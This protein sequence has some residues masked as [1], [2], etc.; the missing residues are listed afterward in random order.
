M[1]NKIKT[2]EKEGKI[3]DSVSSPRK[4]VKRRNSSQK[5]LVQLTPERI[6]RPGKK[7]VAFSTQKPIDILTLPIKSIPKPTAKPKKGILKK[8][9]SL[10]INP[11]KRPT[12]YESE[13]SACWKLG[14]TQFSM[15]VKNGITVV[16]NPLYNSKEVQLRETLEEI[17][18][19]HVETGNKAILDL[20]AKELKHI[21]PIVLKQQYLNVLNLYMNQFRHLPSDIGKFFQFLILFFLY[22]VY[23]FI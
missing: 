4:K 7:T 12:V 21:P 10:S 19:I 22:F 9:H 2:T 8:S 6:P 16:K 17:Y 11:K 14:F 23:L 1:K 18:R 13:R 15:V 5:T 3:R 20:S